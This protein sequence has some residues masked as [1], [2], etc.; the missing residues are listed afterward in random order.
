MLEL[1]TLAY[2]NIDNFPEDN[3]SYYLT[4]MVSL[5]GD[6]LLNEWIES[7]QN[8][9]SEFLPLNKSSEMTLDN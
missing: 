1:L 4:R 3:Y 2:P 6:D 7:L 8:Q 9:E 5:W